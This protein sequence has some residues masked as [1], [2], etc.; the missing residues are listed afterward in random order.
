MKGGT[1]MSKPKTKRKFFSIL[2]CFAMLLSLMPVNASAYEI[3]DAHFTVTAPKAGEEPSKR[4]EYDSKGFNVTNVYWSMGVDTVFQSGET[5]RV[6]IT[7]QPYS[8][9][10]ITRKQADSHWEYELDATI[11]G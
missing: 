7:I 4:V 8:Y 11:N 9:N 5:Y 10:T 1:F 2:L 6:Y 3:Q